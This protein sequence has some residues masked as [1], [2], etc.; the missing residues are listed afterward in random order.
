MEG[1]DLLELVA[2]LREGDRLVLTAPSI[3]LRHR[4]DFL[5]LHWLAGKSRLSTL[6]AALLEQLS[7]Q[8][9]REFVAQG[10]EMGWGEKLQAIRSQVKRMKRTYDARHGLWFKALWDGDLDQSCL[11]LMEQIDQLLAQQAQGELADLDAHIGTRAAQVEK[12]WETRWQEKKQALERKFQEVSNPLKKRDRGEALCQFMDWQKKGSLE[13]AEAIWRDMWE[14]VQ[15]VMGEGKEVGELIQEE[16]S[17]SFHSRDPLSVYHHN[18]LLSRLSVWEGV[19]KE[20]K[21]EWVKKIQKWGDQREE[22]LQQ[23]QAEYDQVKEEAQ[24]AE[25]LREMEALK[26]LYLERER[27]CLHFVEEAQAEMGQITDELQDGIRRMGEVLMTDH[28]LDSQVAA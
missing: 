25:L 7:D 17:R 23:L 13:D 26:E 27:A 6:L 21:R 16:A 11:K 24:Q 28:Y 22:A 4:Q 2:H 14:K 3:Q 10:E 9:V 20:S 19:I 15:Q 8:G 18:A 1:R 12:K 5:Q